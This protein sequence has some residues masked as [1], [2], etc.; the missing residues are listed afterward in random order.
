MKC[1]AVYNPLS[2]KFDTYAILRGV[3]LYVGVATDY[4]H[5]LELFDGFAAMIGEK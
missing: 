2:G 4:T 1:N 3:S 5:A